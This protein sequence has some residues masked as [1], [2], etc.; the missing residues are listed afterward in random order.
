MAVSNALGQNEEQNRA[1]RPSGARGARVLVVGAGGLGSV[2][3][4]AL[5]RWPSVGAIGLVDDDS[6]ELS[7]LHRQIAYSERDVGESKLVALEKALRR[8]GFVG[9]VTQHFG[10]FVPENAVKLASAYD[11]VVEGADNFATKFLV[12]DACAA[13]RVPVVH[14]AAVRWVGTAM[15]VG[16]NGRPCYRCLFE[17]EPQDGAANCAEAGVMGPMVGVIAAIQADLAIAMIDGALT[18][19]V[20]VTFDAKSDELRRRDIAPR[21]RCALCG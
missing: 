6:V 10:R 8:D 2:A 7:N 20:L 5:G 19:G 12:A 18:G 14:G 17:D 9:A 16:A 21:A 4:L 13:A 3:A 1:E 15:A 11:I